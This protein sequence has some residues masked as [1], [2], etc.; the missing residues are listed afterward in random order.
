MCKVN[1]H[2]TLLKF[3]LILESSFKKKLLKVFIY[4]KINVFTTKENFKTQ[5]FLSVISVKNNKKNW[6]ILSFLTYSTSDLK[7]LFDKIIKPVN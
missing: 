1:L 5:T 6:L 7:K 4:K 3:K 2:I